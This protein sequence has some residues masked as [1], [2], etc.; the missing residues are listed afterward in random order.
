[1]RAK[2]LSLCNLGPLIYCC[3]IFDTVVVD[4]HFRIFFYHVFIMQSLQ[5]FIIP[6][7]CSSTGYK[8]ERLQFILYIKVGYNFVINIKTHCLIQVIDL[9]IDKK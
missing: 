4:A 8:I 7:S 1:M 3:A 2:K 5:L 9:G 6:V